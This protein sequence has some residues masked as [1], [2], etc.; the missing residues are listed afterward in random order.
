MAAAF[1][2]AGSPRFSRLDLAQTM[3]L[4]AP[5]F[6]AV[7][8]AV[9]VAAVASACLH[10]AATTTTRLI[11]V[12]AAV[13]AGV[14]WLLPA[15]STRPTLL[16]SSSSASSHSGV[17]AIVVLGG[18]SHFPPWTKVRCDLAFQQF[19][20]MGRK[21]AILAL[22]GGTFHAPSELTE[23]GHVVTEAARTARYLTE[24]LGV[25]AAQIVTETASFDTIGN[26]FFARTMHTDVRGWR[27]LLIITSEFHM[28]RSE[29]IFRTVFGLSLTDSNTHS[30]VGGPTGGGG[31][32]P[33]HLQFLSASDDGVAEASALASRRSKED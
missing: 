21:P 13:L 2:A 12:A 14:A 22:S 8:A 23:D 16:P 31:G 17:D 18:G 4:Q 5:V 33:Y 7:A 29:A 1:S 19:Q 15:A 11:A 27:S 26:A 28:P 24:E 25:P 6:T 30:E 9:V 20:A 3:A 10:R 32:Q